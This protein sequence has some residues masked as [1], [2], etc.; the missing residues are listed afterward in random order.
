MDQFNEQIKRCE[1]LKQIFDVVNHHYDT[2][3]QLPLYTG[4]MVKNKIPK[5]VKQ[6]KLKRK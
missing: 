2:T 5:L 6:L 4:A 1:T 3:E